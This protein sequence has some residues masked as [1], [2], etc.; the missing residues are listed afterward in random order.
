MKKLL[1][2]LL[3]LSVLFALTVQAQ[4]NYRVQVTAFSESVPLDYFEDLEDVRIVRDH[5]DLFRVFLKDY[6]TKA[7]AEA[8]LKEVKDKGY[9]HAIVIDLEE[10]RDYCSAACSPQ[11]YVEN[12]FFDY[13]KS[14]LRTK[15]K[16]DLTALSTLLEKNPAYVVVLSAHTDSHGSNTYN[17]DLSRNR[18]ESA[19]NFLISKGISSDRVTIEYKGE[20]QPIAINEKGDGKDS[21]S[22]RQFNRR[23]TITLLDGGGLIVPN[24]VK[25][26]K[27]PES[28][29]F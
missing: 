22:G 6:A 10:L 12:I 27:I 24:V 25:D 15:S 4:A 29:R 8:A 28:L 3:F 18:A 9:K 26:I 19:R 21:P 5:N 14:F 17:I 11:L 23:V 16:Q 1:F 7:E 2:S 13:D 20:S